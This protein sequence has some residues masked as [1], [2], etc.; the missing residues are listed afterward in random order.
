MPIDIT[1][2]ALSPTMETGTLAKWLVKPGDAVKSGDILAEIETDKATMEVESIDEG[3][4][5]ELLVADGAEDIKVG[6]VIARLTADGE[7]HSTTGEKAGGPPPRAGEDE[8]IN[9]PRNG[10][11]DRAQAGGGG[12]TPP[13]VK[14][15]GA[16]PAADAELATEE[17]GGL[18]T[19]PP[20]AAR[21]SPSP[22][23][24]GPL[25]PSPSG[26]RSPSPCR[27]GSDCCLAVGQAAGGGQGPGS[28]GTDRLRPA[29]AYRQGGCGRRG[30]AIHDAGGRAAAGRG[31]ARPRCHRRPRPH[32]HRFP[33]PRMRRTKR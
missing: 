16:A 4:V 11:G 23:R 20:S 21:R 25:H 10:E 15:Y 5:A 31:R 2:P 19:P 13:E 24:G 12:A 8:P 14:G 9:P 7:A 26:E 32:R 33:C 3:I 6:A 17:A 1:M 18:S 22:C 30:G 29:R 27:G 28:V